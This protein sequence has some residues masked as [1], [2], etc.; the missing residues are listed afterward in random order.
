MAAEKTKVKCAPFIYSMA[1]ICV[2][3]GWGSALFL[4]ERYFLNFS[5]LRIL[6][7][8]A[9]SGLLIAMSFLNATQYLPKANGAL[10]TAACGFAIVFIFTNIFYLPVLAL[11][12][13]FAESP[14]GGNGRVTLARFVAK[15]I[16]M[17]RVVVEDPMNGAETNRIVLFFAQFV[18]VGLLEELTKAAPAFYLAYNA[19]KRTGN[20]RTTVLIS[21]FSSGCAFGVAENL[22]CY[23][24]W[25]GVTDWSENVLR[26]FVLVP[27][28]GLWTVI[29]AA[30]FWKFAPKI[31]AKNPQYH[32]I[33]GSICLSSALHATH[34]TLA[35]YRV[36]A[37]LI[38]FF[39]ILIATHF[40]WENGELKGNYSRANVSE[41]FSWLVA[42]SHS[43]RYLKVLVILGAA[44][45]LCSGFFSSVI[46]KAICPS[47]KGSGGGSS[48]FYGKQVCNFCEGEGYIQRIK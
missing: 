36:L 20:I 16:V 2:G 35:I 42:E 27:S 40:I 3:L 44:S 38:T 18:G 34:N 26:W 22:M 39:S 41:P 5:V 48:W 37:I 13:E 29:S 19:K 8:A 21:A 31:F 14:I 23:A 24:P 45:I 17:G 25:T 12:T 43:S 33:F 32:L 10:R 15:I 7:L 4:P 30:I 28:H 1:I 6:I 11:I 46:Y 9:T 47:C